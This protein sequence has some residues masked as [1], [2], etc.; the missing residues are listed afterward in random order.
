MIHQDSFHLQ[1]FI[2]LDKVHVWKSQALLGG[3]HPDFLANKKVQ[4][5]VN[6]RMMISL[7]YCCS[8]RWWFNDL[9][10]FVS[11]R[12]LGEMMEKFNIFQNGC[13]NN[14][15]NASSCF[16]NGGLPKTVLATQ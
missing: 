13:F 7:N 10:L 9:C 16:L 4:Y 14:I 5:W 12:K 15:R 11:P 6:F 8:F 3:D 1:E 2:K